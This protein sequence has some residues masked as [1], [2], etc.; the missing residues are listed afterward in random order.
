[1][2]K[3][4][5]LLLT[6]FATIAMAQQPMQTQPAP[7]SPQMLQAA[8]VIG[9]IGN[10]VI[11]ASDVM[12]EANLIISDNIDRIPPDQVEEARQSIMQ[13][14]L[15]SYIDT[16]LLYA[17]FRRNA[18]GADMAAIRKQLEEPFFSGGGSGDAPGTV[19]GLIKSLQV[20]SG[21]ALEKRLTELGTS[22]AAR[23]DAYVEKAIA[24][25]W[26]REKVKVD[27]PDHVELVEYYQDHI[28]DYSFPTQV[29]WEE[30]KVS[31]TDEASKQ[32]ARTKL[33]E[34]GNIAWQRVQQ[35]PASGTPLFTDLAP[36]Y[37]D[38]YNAQEGGLHDWTS[39]G[40]L[41]DSSIDTA[42][43]TLPVGSLGPMIETDTSLH[44]VRV[45]ERREAGATPFHELQDDIRGKIMD[46]SYQ[47]QTRELI[48]KLRRETRI[49]TV[50]TGD[51][52][53]E[54]FLQSSGDPSRR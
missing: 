15:R 4:L 10:E 33:A 51:T 46:Q 17:D 36:K 43:F 28:E 5:A 35:N 2:P 37:S 38:A 14:Q 52:T 19:P 18:Q 34:A 44:I 9:R 49:W 12:W 27:K 6:L 3:L 40:A 20:N 21:E 53:A 47:A 50:Y 39:Q 31:F 48:T 42:L 22:T 13:N 7:S 32:A 25:Q 24:S 41:R 23:M 8:Q 45:V 26:M 11:L 29:K 30:L 16:K 1:V 54:A